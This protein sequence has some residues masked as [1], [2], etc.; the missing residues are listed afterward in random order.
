[1]VVSNLVKPGFQD[2][3]AYSHYSLL[4]TIE[5]SWGLKL[6]GHS[7]DAKTTLITAPWKSS[8]VKK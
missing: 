1:M 6:L 2:T 4:K 3:T 7:A 5:A 8:A